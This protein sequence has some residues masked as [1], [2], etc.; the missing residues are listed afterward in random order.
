MVRVTP[1]DQRFYALDRARL[2]VEYRLV[3]QLQLTQLQGV[4]Q[5]ILEG[6]PLDCASG[7]GGVEK[8]IVVSTDV[9]GVVH[10]K[11]RVLIRVCASV[12]S[13]G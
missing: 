3:M 1:A 7:H 12:P 4:A 8:L 11:I 13:S 5:S 10:R 6:V 9:L 2:K